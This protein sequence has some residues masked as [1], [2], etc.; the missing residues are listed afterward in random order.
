MSSHDIKDDQVGTV[1]PLLIFATNVVESSITF[2]HMKYVIDFG[3]YKHSDHLCSMNMDILSIQ[4][5]NKASANQRKGRTG[6]TCDGICFR[7]YTKPMYDNFKPS[8]D[9][10]LLHNRLDSMFLGLLEKYNF[11]N[12]DYI[13]SPSQLQIEVLL[14]RLKKFGYI[15]EKFNI[16][17]RHDDEECVNVDMIN[18]I[19]GMNQ[20]IK[21]TNQETDQ[22]EYIKL[23]V[24]LLSILYKTLPNSANKNDDVI[25]IIFAMFMI[26][27][28]STGRA[29]RGM[30]GQILNVPNVDEFVN[31]TIKHNFDNHKYCTLLWLYHNLN[32]VLNGRLQEDWKAY[33]TNSSNL[34]SYLLNYSYKPSGGPSG[35][36]SGGPSGDSSPPTINVSSTLITTMNTTLQ[37]IGQV[38]GFGEKQVKV[39]NKTDTDIILFDP[40]IHNKYNKDKDTYTYLYCHYSTVFN[41]LF[42][43]KIT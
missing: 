19:I 12:L 27:L 3:N 20:F 4:A 2:P 17:S 1:M 10:D 39:I 24:M 29:G 6:R 18:W 16:Y 40:F 28:V 23:D 7:L 38:C 41:F 37:N 5:I 14:F 26:N 36:I 32:E 9:S 42:L 34:M 33:Y 30:I 13:E 21:Y 35:A 8:K 22:T 43:T 15:T 25:F 11:L 31:R